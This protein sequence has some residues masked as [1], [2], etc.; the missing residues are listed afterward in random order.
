MGD[1]FSEDPFVLFQLRGRSRIKLLKDLAEQRRKVIEDLE[2]KQL[3][4]KDIKKQKKATNDNPLTPHPA[5]LNPNIWW[6]YKGNLP[7]DLVVITATEE[8]SGLFLAGEL[9]LAEEPQHPNASKQFIRHLQEQG[10]I[11]AQEAMIQAM[12]SNKRKEN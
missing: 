10:Q 8:E 3:N 5:I 9:P 11:F 12:S 4:Q 2:T 7:P 1:R 6:Q